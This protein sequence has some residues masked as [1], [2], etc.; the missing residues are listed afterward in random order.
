MQVIIQG[1]LGLRQGDGARLFAIATL[2][3]KDVGKTAVGRACEET[4]AFWSN[5]GLDCVD[6]DFSDGN[7]ICINRWRERLAVRSSRGFVALLH[8]RGG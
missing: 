5:L 6:L 8:L 7:E 4:G 1:S 3:G 2:D